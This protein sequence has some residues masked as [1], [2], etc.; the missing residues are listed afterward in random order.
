MEENIKQMVEDRVTRY[1]E[2]SEEYATDNTI[3]PMGMFNL[4]DEDGDSQIEYDEKEFKK[5]VKKASE[6]SG[7]FT[8]LFNT[9][10]SESGALQVFDTMF[11]ENLFPKQAELQLSLAKIEQIKARE[12]EI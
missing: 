4:F 2:L 8:A 5:G 9:G 3:I 7:I 10:L 1:E 6:I 11:T 12:M